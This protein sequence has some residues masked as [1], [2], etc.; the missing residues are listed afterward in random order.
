MPSLLKWWGACKT[1]LYALQTKILEA[2]TKDVMRIFDRVFTSPL[3]NEHSRPWQ[4][5]P[6]KSA[7]H[8]LFLLP[9]SL[10]GAAVG[11]SPP[12]L[13]NLPFQDFPKYFN[14]DSWFTVLGKSWKG[15]FVKNGGELPTAGLGSI[16]MLIACMLMCQ[17][18]S[19]CDA[20]MID[21]PL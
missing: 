16:K 7:F 19:H 10:F 14:H 18:T 9:K 17:S 8:L 2:G 3:P 4:V 6:S 15:R 5:L 12:F 1:Q 11:N 20:V 13:T 21:S